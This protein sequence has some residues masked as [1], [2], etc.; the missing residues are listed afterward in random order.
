MGES[1]LNGSIN[2]ESFLA[3]YGTKRFL[4]HMREIKAEKLAEMTRNDNQP[5]RQNYPQGATGQ[6]YAKTVRR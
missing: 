4:A 3:E 1:L 5:S 2:V 6:N